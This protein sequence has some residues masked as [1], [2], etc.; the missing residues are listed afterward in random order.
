M[1]RCG[2][3]HGVEERRST[4]EARRG[5]KTTAVACVAEAAGRRKFLL[6]GQVPFQ[7][8]TVCR[9][10]QPFIASEGALSAESF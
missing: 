8:S 3:E 5:K 2:W 10:V 4:R 9:R 7:K 1:K 6:D